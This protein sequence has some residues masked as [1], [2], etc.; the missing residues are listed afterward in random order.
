MSTG[1]LSRRL[2]AGGIGRARRKLDAD[3]E[4]AA[5]QPVVAAAQ[6]AAGVSRIEVLRALQLPSSDEGEGGGGQSAEG[7]QSDEYKGDGGSRS[8]VSEGGQDSTQG[9]MV[10]SA[11]RQLSRTARVQIYVAQYGDAADATALIEYSKR[12]LMA[13]HVQPSHTLVRSTHSP[14][15]TFHP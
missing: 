2:E 6:L 4:G 1:P 11:P 9:D 8:S 13:S 14:H 3:S 5:A 10:V 7:G 12:A 15:F